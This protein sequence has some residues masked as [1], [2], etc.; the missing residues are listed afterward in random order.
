MDHHTRATNAIMLH[1]KKVLSTEKQICW[2]H[3]LHLFKHSRE[4][5]DYQEASPGYETQSLKN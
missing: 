4:S 2:V 1:Q 5:W 3:G